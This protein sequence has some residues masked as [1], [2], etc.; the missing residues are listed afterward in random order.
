MATGRRL[1]PSSS[2]TTTCRERELIISSAASSQ[3]RLRRD[4]GDVALHVIL[5]HLAGPVVPL[6]VDAQ[7]VDAGDQAQQ[8]AFV[9]LDHQRADLLL[10]HDAH[11][12]QQGGVGR[13]AMD[14]VALGL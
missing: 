7:D 4:H 1:P 9:V 5:D 6:D 10:D 8:A 2:T 3:Q 11:G 13:A 12:H 14:A